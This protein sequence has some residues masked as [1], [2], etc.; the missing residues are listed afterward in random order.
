MRVHFINDNDINIVFFPDTMNF[1]EINDFTEE[2]I[3]RLNEKQPIETIIN[4][5][6]A[7]MENVEIVQNLLNKNTKHVKQLIPKNEKILSKL[8]LNVTNTCNLGC[9]Y[10]YASGGNYCSD[11]SIM[12]EDVAIEILDKFYSK[13]ETIKVIQLFGGEPLLNLNAIE[14]VCEYIEDRY[15]QGLIGEK[16]IMGIVTNGTI[17]NEK[18]VNLINSYGL[19]L[20]V[21]LDG[22]PIVNDKMR[23][24][25]DGSKTSNKII[26]NIK[27]LKS[28]TSE[29]SSIE[30]T[31]NMHHVNEKISVLDVASF[32]DKELNINDVHI[33]PASGDE[34]CDFVL[35][36]RNSFINSVDDIFDKFGNDKKISYSLINRV[37][38]SL[39]RKATSKYL[40]EAGIS[41]FS[42]STQGDIYPCFMFTDNEKYK[43]GNI[44]DENLFESDDFKVKTENLKS[45]SK[46]TK[47]ECENCFNNTICTGCLGLNNIETGDIHS[48][49]DTNCDMSRRITEKVIIGIIKNRKIHN[50]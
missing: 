22:P 25:K 30:S 40:C 10:C 43:L 5:T 6:K 4:E 48:L 46:F 7:S 24:Y 20:T 37:I 27:F 26:Q 50:C 11:D 18:L 23:V 44:K 1:Y 49:N 45:F 29:P 8:A 32:M 21:S 39:K 14:K 2:L 36:N 13:Y 47:D 28:K 38:F 12:S 15:I 34:N 33:V 9:K 3:N 41:M 42:A 17:V 16:P 19:K 31:Y 35:K